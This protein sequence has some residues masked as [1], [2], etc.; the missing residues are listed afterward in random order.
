M[1]IIPTSIQQGASISSFIITTLK[2]KPLGV[3]IIFTIADWSGKKL[4]KTKNQTTQNMKFFMGALAATILT[5][6]FIIYWSEG[7]Y[8][9]INDKMINLTDDFFNYTTALGM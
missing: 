2:T 7:I 8:N 9:Y 3:I 4:S 5:G 1:P 6:P